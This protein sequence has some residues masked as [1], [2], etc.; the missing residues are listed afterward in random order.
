MIYRDYSTRVDA[1]KKV[2]PEL[3]QAKGVG[4]RTDV[5]G[6]KETMSSYSYVKYLHYPK[7]LKDELLLTFGSEIMKGVVASNVLHL[8][9]GERLDRTDHWMHRDAPFSFFSLSLEDKQSILVNDEEF[10]LNRGDAIWFKP[11]G[12]TH[13]IKPVDRPNTWIVLV[14]GDYLQKGL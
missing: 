5:H 3:R 2:I 1:I 14:V 4:L 7:E 9:I 12:G 11:D 10:V 13:E 6:N 8:A